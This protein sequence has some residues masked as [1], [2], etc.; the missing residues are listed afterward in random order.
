M[1]KELKADIVL[2]KSLSFNVFFLRL[3]DNSIIFR[4]NQIISYLKISE[5]RETC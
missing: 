2:P 3:F 1:L 5:Y 4:L